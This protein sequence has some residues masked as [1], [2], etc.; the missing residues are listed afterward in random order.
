MDIAYLRQVLGKLERMKAVHDE[1][2]SDN[3]K[4]KDCQKRLDKAIDNLGRDIKEQSASEPR[5]DFS[6]SESALPDAI[7]PAAKLQA[8]ANEL[9]GLNDPLA[10]ALRAQSRDIL[11][12]ELNELDGFDR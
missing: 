4:H 1:K 11:F 10:T 12:K 2:F 7:E 5:L 9:E 3:P 8:E 6:V